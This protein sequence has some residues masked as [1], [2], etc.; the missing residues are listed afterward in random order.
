[1]HTF[2][3]IFTTTS[4]VVTVGVCFDLYCIEANR[5]DEEYFK[6]LDEQKKYIY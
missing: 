2:G 5:A 1:M 4:F 3:L 6:R